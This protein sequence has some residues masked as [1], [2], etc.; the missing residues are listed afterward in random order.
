MHLL[1]ADCAHQ[2]T[3]GP[4]S[5]CCSQ[6]LG[7]L[8]LLLICALWGCLLPAGLLLRLLLVVPPPPAPEAARDP[9]CP[10]PPAQGLPLRPPPVAWGVGP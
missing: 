9:G 1:K 6:L 7:V 4:G 8:L 3:V 5:P 2:G 10:L